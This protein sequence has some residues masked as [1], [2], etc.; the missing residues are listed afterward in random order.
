MVESSSGNVGVALAALCRE[1][2]YAF[3]AVVDPHISARNISLIRASGAQVVQVDDADDSGSFLSS[4]LRE[5]AEL[6]SRPRHFWTNQYG[7]PA[8]PEVHYRQ[9]APELRHQIGS[10]CDALFIA[11]ST[12]G[13]LA[14]IGRFFNEFNDRPEIYGV[15]VEGSVV[16]QDVPGPRNFS[17]I[18]SSRKSDFLL[19]TYYDNYIIISEASAIEHCRALAAGTGLR[20][21][22]SSGAV[23]AA[24]SIFLATHLDCVNVACL[25]P[26][27]GPSYLETIYAGRL[28][29]REWQATTSDGVR[30]G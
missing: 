17:G 13:T 21:G 28:D 16:F 29:D 26:D 5:V 23:L 8:N 27:G 25:C 18:G 30:Y 22:G 9:T 20:V 10:S 24:C 2:G 14:G 6:R 12:G 1:R 3:T 4:R 11:V 7:S 15:D 19:P